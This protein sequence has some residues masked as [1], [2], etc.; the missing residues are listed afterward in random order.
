VRRASSGAPRTVTDDQVEAVVVKTLTETPKNATQW[1]IRDMAK[2]TG[3]SRMAIQR[4]WSAFGL[5]PW[6]TETFKLSTDPLFVDKVRDIVGI[7]LDP[8]ERA[9]VLCADEKSGIQALNRTQPVLALRPGVAERRTHDYV[10]HGVTD[11][12]AALNVA[13]GEVIPI[14]RRRHRATE[15]I[16]FLT[17]INTAV[18]AELDIHLV[19]DNP[20]THKTPAASTCTS[21]PPARPGST[22]SSAGSRSSSVLPSRIPS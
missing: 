11:L 4:I 2:D 15:F 18:P 17:A 5:K 19:I 16:Q 6:R 9:V 7:Y 10:R 22:S 8:P 1:S 3:M 13:T 14:I 21:R 12:F 20:S